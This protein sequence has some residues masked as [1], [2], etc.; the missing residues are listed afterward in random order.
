MNLYDTIRYNKLQ[1]NTN[2]SVTIEYY[3]TKFN[4]IQNPIQHYCTKTYLISFFANTS[5]LVKE[6]SLPP[7]SLLHMHILLHCTSNI[8]HDG[9]MLPA[10]STY[11]H[12]PLPEQSVPEMRDHVYV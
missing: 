2:N 8:V 6:Q 4:G 11:L 5:L 7:K 3:V 1:Y 12:T 9:N 10:A